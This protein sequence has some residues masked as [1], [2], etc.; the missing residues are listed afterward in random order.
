MTAHNVEWYVVAWKYWI[1]CGQTS[2]RLVAVF[3]S[4]DEETGLVWLFV[5]EESLSCEM[6]GNETSYK[7]LPRLRVVVDAFFVTFESCVEQYDSRF[8]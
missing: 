7:I 4:F 3:I 2:R 5:D 1:E 6:T 8:S